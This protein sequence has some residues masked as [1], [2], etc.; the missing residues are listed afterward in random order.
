ML[1]PRPIGR[2]HVQQDP[3]NEVECASAAH[4]EVLSRTK[5][6]VVINKKAL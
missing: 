4:A 5:S 6:I 1:V 2:S 3:Y